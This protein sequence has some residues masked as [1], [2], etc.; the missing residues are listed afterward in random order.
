MVDKQVAGSTDSLSFLLEYGLE[1]AFLA[2][3]GIPILVLLIFWASRAV[4]QGSRRL[5]GKDSGHSSALWRIGH[6]S[7]QSRVAA[8]ASFFTHGISI[9]ARLVTRYS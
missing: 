7:H 2:N 8:Q 3:N 1:L 6:A 9:V 5:V 4:R